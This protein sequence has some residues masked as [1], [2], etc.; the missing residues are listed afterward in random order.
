MKEIAD[1]N[2]QISIVVPVYN[3]EEYLLRCLKSLVHQTYNNIEIIL[4]DDGSTDNSGKICDEF[5]DRYPQ[6]KTV[7]KHNGGLS[8]ARNLGIQ[9]AQG[10][11]IGFVDSDDWIAIDMYEKLYME[12]RESNADIAVCERDLVI[13]DRIV[14]TKCLNSV[15]IMDSHDAL[16]IL[17][18]DKK[19]KSHAWNKLY[20]RELFSNIEFPVGKYYEDILIMYKLFEKAKRIVFIDHAY[21]YYYQRKNSIVGSKNLDSLDDYIEACKYRYFE[22]KNTYPEYSEYLL[23]DIL[24]AYLFTYSQLKLIKKK[25]LIT[26]KYLKN[27]YSRIIHFRPNNLLTKLSLGQ[28][29][30]FYTIKFATPFYPFYRYINKN[31]VVR[32]IGHKLI[33]LMKQRFNQESK[34]RNSFEIVLSET[35]KNIFLFGSPE[36]NNLGDIAIAYATKKFISDYFPESTF[37]E[38][39]EADIIYRIDKIKKIVR[40]GDII[41]LQGGGNISDLYQ[42]QQYIRKK[43]IRAFPK[44]KM[45]LMPQTCCFT[46]TEKGEKELNRTRRLFNKTTN[47]TLIAR[48]KY[49][50]EKMIKE[51]KNKVLLVPDIVLSQHLEFNTPR[52]GVGI[53]LRDDL[54][55]NNTIDD[56]NTIIYTAQEKCSLVKLIDTCINENVT[57]QERKKYLENKL[58]E[59]SQCKLIITDRLHGVIFSVITGTPCIA[60][61]NNNNKVKGICDWVENLELVYYCSDLHDF[62]KMLNKLLIY[63]SHKKF[64]D[65]YPKFRPLI[66]LI[67]SGT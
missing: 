13:D 52:R 22:L 61:N 15:Q 11:Y 64:V 53:C 49:T 6:I 4:V 19:Y 60:I 5:G 3:V 57:I 51:F 36:Y 39:S 55:S 44:N 33:V 12:L 8:D 26:K 54:E 32:K 2:N 67:K 66:E 56:I 9:L 42:D 62:D 47:L 10:S 14:H 29:I 25:D 37:S 59:F 1:T 7:H 63:D 46:S 17:A 45:I 65:L 34:K 18:V 38:I 50:Y 27:V 35:K 58:L 48:E 16:K 43:I 28:R 21:Y 40:A 24:K 23:L 31:I 30:E 20:K 41:L